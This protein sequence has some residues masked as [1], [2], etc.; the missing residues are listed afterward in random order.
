MLL[1]L[2]EDVAAALRSGKQASPRTSVADAAIFDQIWLLRG[3]TY[4][5]T[6]NRRTL[7]VDIGG[8]AYFAKLHDGVGWREI[9]KNLL[10]LKWP[11][12]GASHEYAACRHLAGTGVRVPN[13]AAYGRLGWNPATQ[14]SFVLCEA[15]EQCASLQDVVSGWGRS[16][17]PLALRRQLLHEVALL[18]RDLHGAGVNH[19]DYYLCHLF[20]D[21]RRLARG[22]VAL[23]VIDLHRAGIRRRVPRRWLLRDLAALLYSANAALPENRS[24]LSRTDLFRFVR[25]Y[26]GAG[27]AAVIRR[28]GRFWRAVE[29]RAVRLHRRGH[30]DTAA[31]PPDDPVQRVGTTALRTP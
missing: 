20:V 6:A 7:R 21:T 4:R 13:V 11:I 30:R 3:E 16:P 10:Q 2:R 29:R 9:L 31:L 17:P 18:T 12:L 27:P 24:G 23:A 14:R 25:D 22:E 28:D 5:R 1:Y 26:A 15:L 8:A 19:R